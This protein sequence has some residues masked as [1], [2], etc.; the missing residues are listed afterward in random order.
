MT[1]LVLDGQGGRL[2]SQ[3]V[4]EICARFPGQHLLAVGTNSMATERMLKAG[5]SHA[6]TGENAVAVACRKADVIID[7]TG[8]HCKD[9]L[10]CIGV[11]FIIHNLPCF[12]LVFWSLFAQISAF[13]LH[14]VNS[15]EISV[16]I[17]EKQRLFDEGAFLQIVG[18]ELAAKQHQAGL[19]NEGRFTL[20]AGRKACGGKLVKIAPAF[21]AAKCQR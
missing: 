20:E 12:L 1:V 5:A 14:H 9:I 19:A 6:A 21:G 7:Y 11:N 4:K 2:G 15:V 17:V 13:D 10:I 3:L 16:L 18:I 8:R